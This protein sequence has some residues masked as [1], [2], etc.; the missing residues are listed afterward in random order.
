MEGDELLAEEGVL[1]NE[2]DLAATEVEGKPEKDREA[3]RPGKMEGSQFQRCRCG[4]N[5]LAEPVD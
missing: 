4:A 2:L 1:G 3:R 5:S